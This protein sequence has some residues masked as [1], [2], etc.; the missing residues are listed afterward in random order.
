MNGQ[1]H[2]MYFGS[3]LSLPCRQHVVSHIPGDASLQGILPA[4]KGPKL[5]VMETGHMQMSYLFFS[6]LQTPN[7]F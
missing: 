3:T 6:A 1:S 7:P 2:G 5:S 4:Y